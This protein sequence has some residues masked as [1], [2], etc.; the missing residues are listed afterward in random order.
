MLKNY[1]TVAWRNLQRNRGTSFINIFGL[2]VGMAVTILIGLWIWDEYSYNQSFQHYDRIASL[3]Q[4]GRSA[5]EVWDNDGAAIPM[6][7]AL[8]KD[9]PDDF[10]SVV[11]INGAKAVLA[12]GDHKFTEQGLFMEKDAPNVLSLT[13]ERGSRSGFE[14]ISSILLSSSVAK[15]LF[16]DQ[17]PMGR[18]VTMNNSHTHKVA[19]VYQD[20]PYNTNFSDVGF[21]IP[22]QY[23][24]THTDW[25]KPFV[26]NW[27][28]NVCG[29]IVQLRPN[30][31][32]DKVSAKI[33]GLKEHYSP[34]KEY[35]TRMFLYPMRKW[36]LYSQF[37]NG[38]EE[39][40]LI[41]YVRLFGI[42]GIFVLLLACINF[43]NLSTARSERRA[44]EVGIRK[45]I[46]SLR[47]QLI[48]Q[49]FSESVLVVFLAFV[50][51]LVLVGLMLP[52]FNGVADKQLSIPVGSLSFWL[53]G[54]GFSVLT[55]L[56]A[57]CYPALYLSAFRPIKV[58]K[59]TFR[60][61]RFAALPRQILVVV[62]FSISILLIMGTVVVYR[63]IQFAK[64]RPVGYE[65][66][67][68]ISV[69]ETTP[70]IY[71]NY[72]PLHDELIQS[73]V[74][75]EMSESQGPI[76]N[77]WA[78]D[79][80]F[81]WQGKSPELKSGFAT[82]GV[83]QEYGKT[84]GWQFV[85][86]RDYSRSFGTDTNGLVLNEA[87]V[88]Y[89]GVK[90]PVGMT[91]RWKKENYTVI[92]VIKDMIMASPY[93]EVPQSIYYILKEGG[94]FVNVRLNPRLSMT[95]ALRRIAPIFSKYNP[96]VPFEYTFVDQD[97][98]KKFGEEERIGKLSAFFAI[99]AVLI[100]CL[101]I[102]GLASF[103]AEQRLKEIS[104]RKVLGASVYLLW[105]LLSKDFA[106]LVL[107]ALVIALPVAGYYMSGWLRT[108]HLHTAISWWIF[109][110]T[111]FGALAITLL[112]VSYQSIKAA[113][114]NPAKILRSE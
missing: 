30:A 28:A 58:L 3:W 61:G 54:I 21:I 6:A 8:R 37:K 29:L 64:D 106:L 25:M 5:K 88:K 77:I 59:G 15:K 96:G 17:D 100:S 80:G 99:L 105:R 102:F 63:Q 36:R 65:R 60:A 12:N 73:G 101:G 67:G 51:S 20:L 83:R 71:T 79:N 111:A 74:A 56:I 93:E 42:I 52:W 1:L 47:G 72:T 32:L 35:K 90:N 4:E 113:M 16:G 89:M 44:K 26:T 57:G 53:E 75:V 95:E 45:A 23:Y 14:D 46:G 19:G 48:A 86:G 107:I 18:I 27:D 55:G 98:A 82:V 43:M 78:G 85:Q 114:T 2:S 34:N 7:E 9:Y 41:T 108:Y 39:G 40:G 62:Q 92:G 110:W 70:E 81:E 87:A 68:L 94:N 112:T 10:Q 13:M 104:I 84:I 24:I 11:L 69:Q 66:R 103:V 38:K 109:A 50:L 22:W 91:I 49:F 97:Y 76:T 31:D 33:V